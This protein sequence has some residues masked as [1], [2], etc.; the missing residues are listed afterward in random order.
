MPKIKNILLILSLSQFA[1]CADILQNTND[2][3]QKELQ[4]QNRDFVKLVVDEISKSLPQTIDK[5][6]SFVKIENK[7]LTLFYTFAINTGTK[8]DE[9]IKNED[10]TRMQEAV[11]RGV[12][13]SSKKFLEAQ[14][15]IS[16]VYINAQTKA[17]LFQF[18]I[19]QKNC[20][21]LLN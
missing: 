13:K 20:L 14:I 8:S 11:T 5:Y 1:Y 12:C 17:K 15:N 10:K 4:S 19:T 16:Y 6:T 7:D 3:P 9:S 18:D 21:E 2:F